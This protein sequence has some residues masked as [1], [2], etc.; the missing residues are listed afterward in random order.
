MGMDQPS[1]LSA[2][3]GLSGVNTSMDVD[4][5]SVG[6]EV[7]LQAYMRVQQVPNDTHPLCKLDEL[8]KSS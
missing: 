8:L 6:G 1:I 5:S 3:D 7:E 2:L 4:L